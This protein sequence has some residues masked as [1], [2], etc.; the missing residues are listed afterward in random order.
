MFPAGEKVRKQMKKKTQ[1]MRHVKWFILLLSEA[2]M[3]GLIGIFLQDFHPPSLLAATITS[4]SQFVIGPNERE[5][6]L[7]REVAGCGLGGE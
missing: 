1:Q 4:P 2:Y 5:Q 7:W 3:V 6:W